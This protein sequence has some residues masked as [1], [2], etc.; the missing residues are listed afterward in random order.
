MTALG[1]NVTLQS[2]AWGDYLNQ[3]D[4]GSFQIWR[5]GWCMDY[6]D[7]SNFLGDARC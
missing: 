4:T 3:L 1:V 2:L 6:P 5:M 7:A